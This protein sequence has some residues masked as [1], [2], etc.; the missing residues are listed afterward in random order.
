VLF[1]KAFPVEEF[2]DVEGIEKDRSQ[3]AKNGRFRH[4]RQNAADPFRIQVE[5]ERER[6]RV[7]GKYNSSQ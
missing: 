4:I 6:E 2:V 7:K 3:E 1:H 5:R